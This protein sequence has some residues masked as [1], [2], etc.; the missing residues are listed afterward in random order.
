MAMDVKQVRI[1]RFQI[2]GVRYPVNASAENPPSLGGGVPV[3]S[4]GQE[5]QS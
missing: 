5:T 2:E 4:T 3:I 1:H